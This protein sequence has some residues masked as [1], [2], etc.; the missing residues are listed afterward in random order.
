MLTLS[1]CV[2]AAADYETLGDRAYADRDYADA[3]V[4]YRLALVRRAPDADLRVKAGLAAL[5]SGD[6]VTATEEYVALAL[7]GGDARRDEAADGLARVADA[8]IAAG[9]QAALASALDGLQQVAPGR[10]LGSFARQLA[11]SLGTMARSPEALSVLIYAAAAA[12]DARLQD[13]LMYAYGV[14]LRRLQRC[15]DAVPT[16]ESLLRRQ[17][18]SS[19]V[20]SSR[21]ELALCALALGRQALD[22]GQPAAAAEWF[23]R[24]AQGGGDSPAAR[25]AYI[26]LG[27]VRF[28]Q[29]DIVGAVQA[30]ER[31]RAGTSPRD[32]IYAIVAERLNRLGRVGTDVP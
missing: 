17:R 30:F 11:G 7:E 12:P 13:S 1:A 8:A 2:G 28:A 3:L 4:E 9:D 21:E 22:R 14:V 15:E 31:A 19:I 32:S 29:G 27:D 26:G 5:M 20:E 16:F 18:A 25:V 6:L 10:A 23:S 24:A